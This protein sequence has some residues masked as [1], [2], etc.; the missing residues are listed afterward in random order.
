MNPDITIE[1]DFD[2]N[3]QTAQIKTNAKREAVL[4]LMTDY[5]HSQIG[6][7]KDT[8]PPENR[9]VYKIILGVELAEDSW[10]S[11]HNCGNK[12][13][14]DGIVMKVLHLVEMSPDK[15]TYV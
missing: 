3:G 13:L 8:S 14:R 9:D 12:G 1:I 7:G 2:I 11:Y 4:E 15:I 10:G 5:I 6:T